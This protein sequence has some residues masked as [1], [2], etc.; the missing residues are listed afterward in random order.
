VECSGERERHTRVG[1]GGAK[2]AG[3]GGTGRRA[4]EEF[5]VRRSYRRYTVP[6]A[7]QLGKGTRRVVVGARNEVYY[8]I[9]WFKNFVRIF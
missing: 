6:L 8:T 7:K 1:R 9:D 4:A 2:R 5:A 3:V